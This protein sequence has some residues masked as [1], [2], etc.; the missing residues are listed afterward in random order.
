VCGRWWLLVGIVRL[1]V[2]GDGFT[3]GPIRT[4]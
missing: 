3:G 1:R 2:G 4:R